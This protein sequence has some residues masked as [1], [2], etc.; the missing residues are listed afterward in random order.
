MI[1]AKRPLGVA[2]IS[3]LYFVSVAFYVLL[4]ALAV[5]A[6]ET[7]RSLLGAASPQGSGPEKLLAFGRLLGIYFA[8]MA[9]LAG[10]LGYG[11]WTL[12]NWSRIVTSIIA[13]VT[14]VG[15]VISLA[16]LVND[17][18]LSALLVGLVRVGLSLLVLWYLWTPGVRAA[19][20]GR[21]LS[22]AA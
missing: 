7:L 18:G 20:R 12:R 8:V 2:L 4:T 9:G 17:L 21:P 13:A 19:F 16:G 11:M 1:A 14:L 6:P 3:A 22:E 15:S 5:V 10:L